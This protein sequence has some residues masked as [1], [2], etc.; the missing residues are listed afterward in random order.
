MWEGVGDRTELQH[1]D[2]H[3][4]GHQSF[5]PV[6]QGAPLGA[7]F[8]YHIWSGLQT[9]WLPVF[10]ELYNSS[11]PLSLEWHVWLSLSGNN[12]HTVH[13]SLSSGALVWLYCGI[14]P[15]PILSAKPAYANGIC[16]FLVFGMACLA[17]SE[18]NIQHRSLQ[19]NCDKRLMTK[20]I[21]KCANRIQ[22]TGYVEQT[23]SFYVLI[24]FG[25]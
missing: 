11:L 15:C 12:C 5:F 7:G 18:V 1:I 22:I 25:W 16:N 19:G 21:I 3:S 10:T 17:G 13:R 24:Y 23:L 20:W 8:L 9:N 4:Y 14:L 2:P 6:L